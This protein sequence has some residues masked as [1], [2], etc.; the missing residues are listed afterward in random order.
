MFTAIRMKPTINP[1]KLQC[2][3]NTLIKWQEKMPNT[4]TTSQG[5][6]TATILQFATRR[7]QIHIHDAC[8][9]FYLEQQP[10]S[11]PARQPPN[12]TTTPSSSLSINKFE[13]S[14]HVDSAYV[15]FI[16]APNNF[17]CNTNATNRGHKRQKLTHTMWVKWF[18][19]IMDPHLH[20]TRTVPNW[21]LFCAV[22]YRVPLFSKTPN[23]K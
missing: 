12:K 1:P 13:I 10:A 21:S 7:N 18:V 19:A 15:H 9:T 14:I 22:L 3:K 6:T 11:Q 4:V 16:W 23:R 17:E 2:K 8:S 20:F 5:K